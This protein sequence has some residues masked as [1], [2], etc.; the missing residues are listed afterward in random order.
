MKLLR[1][2]AKPVLRRE[3]QID[4]DVF[5]QVIDRAIQATMPDDKSKW[6]CRHEILN[7]CEVFQ[8][9]SMSMRSLTQ[10]EIEPGFP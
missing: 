2:W 3:F 7:C 10:S 8:A 9:L 1:R 6:K 5:G 4:A